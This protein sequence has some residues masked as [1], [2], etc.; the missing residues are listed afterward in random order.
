MVGAG[1][2]AAI[3]PAAIAAGG[4]LLIGLAAAAAVA[5]CNATSSAR[6]AARHPVSGG[7]YVYGRERLGHSWG[8]L[9]GWSFVIGKMASCAAMALTFGS[10]AGGALARP[11]AVGAVATLTGVNL[12]GV[13]KTAWLTR[14]IVAVVLGSLATLVTA[15]L[16]ETLS[17]A[18]APIDT[19]LY[20]TLMV[21]GVKI[22]ESD[23][24][25]WTW[26]FGTV[27]EH[28]RHRAAL[29]FC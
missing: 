28:R 6:L 7:T 17:V 11:L 9:A 23:V 1:V 18:T 14:A 22:G 25:V 19:V 12:L 2:F 13:Q 21:L 24:R 15:A 5:Y 20:N 29:Q 10:Y 26:R 16:A 27:E 3:G 8:F 4:G